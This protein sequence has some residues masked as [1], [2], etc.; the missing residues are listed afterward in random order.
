M[1]NPDQSAWKCFQITPL[2]TLANH[3][4]F[5]KTVVEK[6][7]K[8]QLHVWMLDPQLPYYPTTPSNDCKWPVW[9]FGQF[10]DKVYFGIRAKRSSM[11]LFVILQLFWHGHANSGEVTTLRRTIA[12]E[13]ALKWIMPCVVFYACIVWKI[14]LAQR[15]GLVLFCIVWYGLVWSNMLW[16]CLVWC[17]YARIV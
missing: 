14:R 15:N 1:T 4:K 10:C 8:G 16:Y 9:P 12:K 6:M 13:S 17:F 11:K 5:C 7:L 3:L 2:E